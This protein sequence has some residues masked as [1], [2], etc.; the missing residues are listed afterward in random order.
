MTTGVAAARP[1]LSGAHRR[2]I[3]TGEERLRLGLLLL[4][5]FFLLVGVALPILPLVTKSLTDADGQWVGLENYIKY[6]S[7]PGLSLSLQHSLVVATITTVLAVGLALVYALALTRTCLAGRGVFHALALIPLFVPSVALAIGLV[8]LFGNKG[9]V[10]TGLLGFFESRWG[11][12]VGFD[13]HLYGR[14]GIILGELLY[15]FPQ[16]FLILLVAASLS[17]AR[18]Y[19]A[20]A[21]LRA[22]RT[23]TFFTV[24]LP[25]LRYGLISAAFVCF[26]LAFTDFGIP[27]VVGGNYNMLAT[28]IYK[29]VIGQQNFAMGATISIVLL[30]PTVLA[31]L[32]DRIYQRRHS[33]VLTSRSVP[34]QPRPNR[35][36]DRLAFAYCLLIALALLTVVGTIFFASLVDVW[37]YKL[38]LTLRHYDFRTVG[39]GGWGAFW[40]SLRMST[41]TAFFGVMVTF[42]AAYL[43]EKSRNWTP[44]RGFVYFLGM[45]PVALPGLVIGLA[46]IFFFNPRQWQVGGL[47]IP[48]PFAFI[49][50][51]MAI[52]VLA[53]T[54]HFF[55]VSF[56]TG[57]TA[58]KQVDNDFEAVSESL[59]VPF[60]R[61]FWRIT[62]PLCML[63]IFEIGL[64]YF[65]NAMVT[66]SAVVFLY[67]PDLKLASVAIVNMDDAGETASAAAMSSLVI[68]ACLCVRWL[69]GLSVHK[70][71]HRTQAWRRT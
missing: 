60:Y 30:V 66:V 56:M 1:R 8:Y 57:T 10:T 25:G 14:N 20:S 5:T 28:E 24:T 12:P 54:I 2:T 39:G 17:D 31:F 38:N 29:Q 7:S 36:V 53:N 35:R 40:N 49:Y 41:Y 51:T 65:V 70:L 21:A 64:Y 44:I 68:L 63:A 55:T 3:A 26:T 27:K 11:I 16:A 13:I 33:A 71:A 47:T 15:C 58:L 62:V 48:N 32:I 23:R 69:Y 61:S 37:P 34:F 22:S 59:R 43:I 9:L 50:G 6:F 67:P 19:E 18:L 4:I 45:L 46:Y 42:A 52:L